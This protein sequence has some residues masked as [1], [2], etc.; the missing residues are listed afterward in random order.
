[1]LAAQLVEGEDHLGRGEGLVVE[2]HG[3]A[4]LEID[5]DF[6]GLV[7]GVL[8]GRAVAVAALGRLVPGILQL[9][10]LEGDVQEVGV[11]APGLGLGDGHGDAV[12]LGVGHEVGA[13]MHVPLAPGGE[14]F[15]LGI[16][17]HGGEFEAHLI[18]ALAG[19]A[20]G[21]GLGAFGPGHLDQAL[22]DQR[23]G[24]GSAEQI[25]TLVDGTG[26]QHRE[27]EILGEF[28]AQVVDVGLGGAGM[29]GLGLQAVEFLFLAQIAGDGDDLTSVGLLDPFQNNRGI[30][31]PGIGQDDFL[32]GAHDRMSL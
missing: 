18:V 32:D 20:V 1:V 9:A 30:E 6:L 19:G 17:R 11:L 26:T 4:C 10:A 21:H 22:G 15:E 3:V 31:P 16:E 13:G 27:D 14:G 7:R 29:Q 23:P 24:D 5:G 12:L 2:G 25:A 8:D 28:L